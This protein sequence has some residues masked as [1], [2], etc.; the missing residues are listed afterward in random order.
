MN[1]RKDKLEGVISALPAMKRPTVAPLHDSDYL[2]VTTVVDKSQVN[3][4]LPL[5][6]EKGA[7]DILEM[8]ISKIV[9]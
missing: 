9:R 1:V 7:E 6:K 5:L 8:E 4:L 3:I 2:E